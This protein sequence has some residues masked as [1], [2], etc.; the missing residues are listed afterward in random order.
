MFTYTY[1]YIVTIKLYE[2]VVSPCSVLSKLWLFISHL[3]V[4]R[5]S[6]DREE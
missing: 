5:H 2:V 1:M 6:W 3:S 4:I